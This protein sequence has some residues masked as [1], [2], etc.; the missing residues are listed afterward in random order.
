MQA[1]LLIAAVIHYKC[2]VKSATVTGPG[3]YKNGVSPS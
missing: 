1:I 3:K 2:L